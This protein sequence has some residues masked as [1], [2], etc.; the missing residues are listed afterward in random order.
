[1]TST[2]TSKRNTPLK[3]KDG[4]KTASTS[5]ASSTTRSSRKRARDVAEENVD[6]NIGSGGCRTFLVW[7]SIVNDLTD[8]F[9]V[10]L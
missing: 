10:G 2:R 5:T 1:M 3:P 6:S 9:I 4:N 8:L 7:I